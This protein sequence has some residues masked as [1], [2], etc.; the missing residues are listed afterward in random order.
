[1][2]R[3]KGERCGFCS[4]AELHVS[5]GQLS[6]GVRGGLGSGKIALF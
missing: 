4:G 1:M 6:V 3:R 5:A 2:T